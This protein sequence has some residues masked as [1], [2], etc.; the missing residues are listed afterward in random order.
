VTDSYKKTHK[1]LP[2]FDAIIIGSGVGSLCTAAMLS[3]EGKK[4]LV[5]ERHY[6]IGGYSH[7]FKRSGYEWDVGIHY[8][9]EVGR[10]DS[11]M[12]KLFNYITDGT[13]EWADMGDVY[14]RIVIGKKK[15][16]LVKG[17]E[18]FKTNLIQDFPEE[19]KAINNY[20]NLVFKVVKT[21]SLFFMEKAI[22]PWLGAIFG[23]LL[24]RSYLKYSIKTTLEV[25]QSLTKNEKLIKVLTGQ[26][27]DYG[28]PPSQSSFAMHAT[29]VRHYFS[30]GYFPI[31]GSSRIAE[32]IIPIIN[33]AGGLLLVKAE[34]DEIIVKNG[35][36]VGVK[37]SDGKQ[38]FS[39]II[40]SGA[41]IINTYKKL[42]P[43]TIA[44]ELDLDEQL[45]KMNPSAAHISLYIGLNG[46]PEELN[47]PKPNY[48]VYPE[49]LTHD[50]A[51]DNYVNDVQ[52]EFPVVYI[53]FPSAKDPDWTNRYP[54]KSTIDII[55]LMP[56]SVFAKWDDSKWKN[57]EDEYEQLKEQFSKRLLE[58]LFSLEP[59]LRDKIDCYEL[60]T[61]LTTKHF[62]NYD[63]GEIYGIDHSPSRFDL[64]FLKP[65]TPIKNFY[66]TGQD[67]ATAGIGGALVSGLLTS[68]AIMNK[69]LFKKVMK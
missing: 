33:K 50:E 43:K 2:T 34:V 37:M 64:K 41:G 62:V 44:S 23:K 63:K 18:N 12:Q 69:S 28:L 65:R 56:Y 54:G 59:H 17:V 57:R 21:S 24:R 8:I 20:V 26:Y 3:K 27:G 7:V 5:L 66:L 13:L 15:Y 67:I 53:S 49:H 52:Q 10:E 47:L 48:W 51:I 25:L 1:S 58:V 39:K 40:V 36:A 32:S 4:V 35:K 29:L 6:V 9:G 68:S 45:K 31:G 16:D 42:M 14:D 46:T 55:T 60:S 22:H 38:L 61:P 19:E 30:G 11:M